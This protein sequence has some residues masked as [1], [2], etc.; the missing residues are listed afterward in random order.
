MMPG[1]V[2]QIYRLHLVVI[3]PEAHDVL[4]GQKADGGQEQHPGVA[5]T[6]PRKPSIPKCH[7]LTVAGGGERDCPNNAMAHLLASTRKMTLFSST[8]SATWAASES[9]PCRPGRS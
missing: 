5:G 2:V 8:V 4:M 3:R 1:K 9:L 7:S 6:T